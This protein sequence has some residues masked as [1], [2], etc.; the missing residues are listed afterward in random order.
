VGDACLFF[1]YG[2]IIAAFNPLFVK[3]R[4]L[5][6]YIYEKMICEMFDMYKKSFISATTVILTVVLF[7]SGCSFILGKRKRTDFDE[8]VHHPE[9]VVSLSRAILDGMRHLMNE[10]LI[11]EIWFE[12]MDISIK[13]GN[14]E[15]LQAKITQ[16][17][18]DK[19]PSERIFCQWRIFRKSLTNIEYTNTLSFTNLLPKQSSE[20]EVPVDTLF[21]DIYEPSSRFYLKNNKDLSGIKIVYWRNMAMNDMV[22]AVRMNKNK[23]EGYTVIYPDVHVQIQ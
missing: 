13:S 6:V 2:S 11:S 10:I 12:D 18:F 23:D 16:F 9:T 22:A 17:K 14:A 1:A 20:N 5:P 8:W 15:F 7:F 3:N 21:V 4:E 19:N